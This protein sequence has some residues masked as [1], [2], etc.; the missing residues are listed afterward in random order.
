MNTI[1]CIQSKKAYYEAAIQ[2]EVKLT[3][4]QE[5]KKQAQ[6]RERKREIDSEQ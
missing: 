5:E 1:E 6:G 3:L 2:S 4:P